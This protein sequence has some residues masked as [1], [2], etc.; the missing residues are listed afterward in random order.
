M[1]LNNDDGIKSTEI[2]I[3]DVLYQSI[4]L[5]LNRNPISFVQERTYTVVRPRP[6]NKT[7]T[8]DRRRRRC[9]GLVGGY[10]ERTLH[11]HQ[12]RISFVHLPNGIHVL[13]PFVK[14]PPLPTGMK[15]NVNPPRPFPVP[16][17]FTQ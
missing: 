3:S 15:Q 6:T 5:L 1:I 7:T 16:K 13:V 11:H 14:A 2:E 4:K 17:L 12:D 8:N 10:S 9:C